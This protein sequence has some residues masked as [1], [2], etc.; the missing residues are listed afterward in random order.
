M[1]FFQS[2][3]G[4]KKSPRVNITPDNVWLTTDSKFSGLSKEL[5]SRSPEDTIAVLLVAHFPDVLTRLK[6]IAAEN[7]LVPT[8]AIPASQIKPDIAAA[9]HLDENATVDIIVAERHPLREIDERLK[10]F[11]AELPCRC[12]I[13]HH[14]SM[15]D[16]LLRLFVNDRT[17]KLM[18]QIMS[19]GESIQS[20]MVSQRIKSAQDRIEASCRSPR[21]ADSA[22]NWIEQ[23]CPDAKSD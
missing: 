7:H 8:L 21:D 2:L 10:Q 18:Q 16:P 3:F 9:L 19:A 5:R 12:R 15:E 23:N 17:R 6:K 22:E 4:A 14:L 1:G 11:A 20:N 13:T